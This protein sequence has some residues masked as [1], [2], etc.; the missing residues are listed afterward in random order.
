MIRETNSIY[1]VRRLLFGEQ[2]KSSVHFR[3]QRNEQMLCVMIQRRQSNSTHHNNN[4]SVLLLYIIIDDNTKYYEEII[5][6][7]ERLFA[8]NCGLVI[9]CPCIYLPGEMKY[10]AVVLF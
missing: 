5:K 9:L 1:L 2:K 10:G 6:I 8:K 4:S 3:F 7:V